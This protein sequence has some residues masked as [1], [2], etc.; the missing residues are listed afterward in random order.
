M[1]CSC[2]IYLRVLFLSLFLQVALNYAVDYGKKE[3]VKA[4]I[5]AKANVN[6]KIV[7]PICFRL[8]WLLIGTNGC[9]Y[10]LF[11]SS[12]ATGLSRRLC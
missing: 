11:L 1:L 9:E 3:F 10:T 8:S 7:S 4:L 6:P 12:I 5:E 2:L